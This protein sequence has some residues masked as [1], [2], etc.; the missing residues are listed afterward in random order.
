MTVVII[1]A[2]PLFENPIDPPL[3]LH[4]IYVDTVTFVNVGLQNHDT[5]NQVLEFQENLYCEVGLQ[6]SK[7]STHLNSKPAK[8]KLT[9]KHRTTENIHQKAWLIHAMG[10]CLLQ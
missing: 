10:H 7:T 4:I 8:H 5:G 9:H 2:P 6:D 3:S 1:F